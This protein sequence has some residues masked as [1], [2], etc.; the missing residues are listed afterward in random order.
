MTRRTAIQTLAA[1]PGILR[2][3]N[4]RPNIV[5][6]MTDDQRFDAMSCAGNRILSTPNMDRIAS[7]GVRFR[8]AFVTNSLCSPSRATIVT[9]IYSHAHGV[10]TNGGSTHRL[11]PD[12][13]TFPALLR[14]AGYYTAL[15]G[16]WHI[17]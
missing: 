15:T 11:R 7:G 12:Q 10:M 5:F 3:Q 1:F 4:R 8:Q 17:A 6:L 16:K 2:A 13:V 14:N 9:G